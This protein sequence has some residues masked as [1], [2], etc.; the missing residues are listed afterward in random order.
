MDT[1]PDYIDTEPVPET[2]EAVVWDYYG[3]YVV[4]DQEI[5]K[6]SDT[7]SVTVTRKK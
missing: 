5:G 4:D 6:P 2:K 7:I 3:I 1:K